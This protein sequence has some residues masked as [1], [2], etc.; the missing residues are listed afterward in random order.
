MTTTPKASASKAK[1]TKA[2]K[3]A[4]KTPKGERVPVSDGGRSIETEYY[5]HK[6]YDAMPAR[7]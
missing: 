3:N 2:P 6:R 7:Y 1:A 5:N 4:A